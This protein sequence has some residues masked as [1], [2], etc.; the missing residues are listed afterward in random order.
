MTTMMNPTIRRILFQ[1]AWVYYKPNMNFPPTSRHWLQLSKN[2]VGVAHN[3]KK[4]T[5][6]RSTA[7]KAIRKMVRAVTPTVKKVFRCDLSP[8]TSNSSP[9]SHTRADGSKRPRDNMQ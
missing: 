2:P 6:T 7:S 4:M 9:G 5:I 3:D 1:E 8:G